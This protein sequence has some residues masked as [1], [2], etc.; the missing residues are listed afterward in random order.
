MSSA[1]SPKAAWPR[2]GSAETVATT[3]GNPVDSAAT[4][5]ALFRRLAARGYF[6]VSPGDYSVD[7]DCP[8]G[9]ECDWAGSV[10]SHS[11]P[12]PGVCLTW[13]PKGQA[14][15]SGPARWNPFCTRSI[16][17]PTLQEALAVMEEATRPRWGTLEDNVWRHRQ[18]HARREVSV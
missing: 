11:E 9:A 3:P 1:V 5:E 10:H 15:R 2:D 13:A 18:E 12:R 8:G 14:A 16:V 7:V 6:E 17:R 4:V